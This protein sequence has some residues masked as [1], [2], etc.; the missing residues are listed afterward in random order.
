MDELIPVFY[1]ADTAPS[2]E[3]LRIGA[4][5]EAPI[6]YVDSKMNLLKVQYVDPQH[7]KPPML[8]LGEVDDK[9]FN[10]PPVREIGL[11]DNEELAALK[12]KRR[13]VVIFSR[14]VERWRLPGIERQ[15]DTCFCLPL[16]GLKDYDREFVVSLRAFKYESAFYLPA[17]KSLGMA[18]SF[19]RFDRGQIVHC[20]HIKRWRP[21][22][23]LH[24]D[25]LLVL[26]EWFRYYT[27][28]VA[29]DWVLQYQKAEM[30]KLQQIFSGPETVG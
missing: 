2:K 20:H 14:S 26:Q 22:L 29:E 7:Q 13:P 28:G 4:I 11:R 1:E 6:L 18:E 10:H 5:F 21:P 24:E 19:I 17:E 30:E 8:Q 3:A 25:A 16:Y 23:R 15:I 12:C 9:S 27:T